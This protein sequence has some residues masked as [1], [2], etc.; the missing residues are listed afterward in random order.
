MIVA[1]AICRDRRVLRAELAERRS[2]DRRSAGRRDRA[3]DPAAGHRPPR[4]GRRAPTPNNSYS[5][6]IPEHQTSRDSRLRICGT[7]G[8]FPLRVEM[9]AWSSRT[10]AMKQ[11]GHILTRLLLL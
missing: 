1:K 11:T 2:G 6:L 10:N 5:T 3:R 8:L 7:S 4:P 9:G